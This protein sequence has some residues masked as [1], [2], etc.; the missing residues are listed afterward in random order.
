M[1]T[2]KALLMQWGMRNSG[3]CLK[4]QQK[5][6]LSQSTEGARRPTAKL[7]IVFYLYSPEGATCLA[8]PTPYRLKI[9]NFSY[10]LSFSVLIRGDP[11]E[12]MEKLYGRRN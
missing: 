9:A 12:F 7:S 11:F 5:Q 8:Q 1:Q 3:A 6:D 4:A 10:P 2:R